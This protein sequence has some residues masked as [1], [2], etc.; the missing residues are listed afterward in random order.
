METERGLEEMIS[1]WKELR[2]DITDIRK[3]A[4]NQEQHQCTQ[5]NWGWTELVQQEEEH[6]AKMQ[7]LEKENI[8]LKRKMDVF[9]SDMNNNVW[10]A[11]REMK[12]EL[13]NQKEIN[14]VL[15]EENSH[16]KTRVKEIEQEKNTVLEQAELLMKKLDKVENKYKELKQYKK[17]LEEEIADKDRENKDKETKKIKREL[18]SKTLALEQAQEQA[19]LCREELQISKDREQKEKEKRQ[20]VLKRLNHN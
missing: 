2:G 20:I 17:E 7:D 13:D 16:L 3:K 9:Q 6:N 18:D 5:R 1:R 10:V 14:T 19:K 12:E 8:E 4:T 15:T 11:R